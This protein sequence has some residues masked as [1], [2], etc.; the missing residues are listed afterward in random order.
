MWEVCPASFPSLQKGV[1]GGSPATAIQWFLGERLAAPQRGRRIL[2]HIRTAQPTKKRERGFDLGRGIVI[3]T[4]A[5]L[6]TIEGRRPGWVAKSNLAPADAIGGSE[7]GQSSSLTI[8]LMAFVSQ[9]QRDEGKNSSRQEP[10][11]EAGVR[12]VVR[13]R[14]A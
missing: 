12:V 2:W 11:R 4:L 5:S 3:M 14:P 13:G 6:I 8:R 10:L 1:R 9:T 7:W